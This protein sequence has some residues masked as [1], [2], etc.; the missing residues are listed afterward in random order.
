MSMQQMLRDDIYIE[1][2]EGEQIGPV[3]A[4]VQGN[5]VFIADAR[6]VIEEGGRILRPLP[7]GKSEAHRI[8]Q[9]DFFNDPFGGQLSHY[10][11]TTRKE[12]SLVQTPG[13][14]NINISHSEGIQIGDQ[15]VQNLASSIQ[16]LIE[17]LDDAD[18]P[19]GQKS[20]VKTILRSLLSH[21]L[22][23]A[24]LGSAAGAL[25]QKL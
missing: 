9:V 11:V 2:K 5:K 14:T 6:L 15:N 1:S 10:E 16:D 19:A 22:V 4:S 17:A 24:V 23:A 25:L 12:S 18:V 13:T 20:E 8:L 3:K 7:N 21:P